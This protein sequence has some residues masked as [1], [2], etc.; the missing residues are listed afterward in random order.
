MNTD[1]FRVLFVNISDAGADINENI[2]VIVIVREKGKLI[3]WDATKAFG[4]IAPNSNGKH[5][6]IHK[7]AFSKGKRNPQLNDII[8]YTLVKDKQ[9]RPAAEQATFSGEKLIKKKAK[10]RSVFS[11]YVALIFLGLLLAAM[12]LSYL[13]INLVM[14]YFG[15]S[16][17]TMILYYLDK[18]RAQRNAWRTAE[19]T[20]HLFALLGGWPG[21]A[22][23]QQFLRHKTQK[24]E[25]RQIYWFT[26]ILNCGLLMWLMSANGTSLMRIFY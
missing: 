3:K 1:S 24:R 26:V 11:I 5:V 22:I 15:V 6:F 7:S 25:F 23:A 8:T 12:L 14:A 13:P 2:G 18:L 21:A 10:G 20:L 19:S 9:G 17:L 4:F 16:L